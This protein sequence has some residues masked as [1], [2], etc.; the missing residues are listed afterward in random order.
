MV[1][2]PLHQV[3]NVQF[4]RY[5]RAVQ[6]LPQSSSASRRTPGP[7]LRPACDPAL[8]TRSPVLGVRSAVR[9]RLQVKLE[10]AKE[11][12]LKRTRDADRPPKYCTAAPR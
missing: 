9:A 7:P 11:Q 5:L 4:N 1:S 12:V 3:R 2:N 6:A 10:L 8:P